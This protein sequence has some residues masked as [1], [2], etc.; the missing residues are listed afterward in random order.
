MKYC[1]IVLLL[2]FFATSFHLTQSATLQ[3]SQFGGKPNGDIA[4]A[5]TSAWAQAC[6]STSA[7]KIVIPAGTYQM[8]HVFLKGPCKAPIELSVDATIKAPVKPEDVGGDEMLRIDYADAL[9]ISGKG[10]FD[11]QGSYAWKQNDCSKK[12]SCKLLGMNF[13]FNFVTNSIVRGITSKDSKHF[14]V[15][16]LGCKNFTFDGFKVTAPENSAN[17][18]G[19]HIGRST[20][21]NVLNT[22]IGTGDDCVSL[23]DGS[24]QVLVQ[25]VKCGP[26]HGISIGSLGKYKEEEPVDGITIKSC[27]IKGTQNGVRIKTWPSQPGTITVTNMR[28]EDITMDNVS[29]PVI[30]DQEYCP[31]NQCTKQYP[32]KIK[33]SKVIIKNIKGTSATKEGIILACSSGVPCEGVEISNVDLKFN[34]A[35][36]IAVCSNVKP[37]ITGKV[38]PCTAPSNKKQ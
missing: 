9:T 33:I 18:D 24:K 6:A 36:A 34:G 13:A 20:G 29:N 37:K 35:P 3:I 5:L 10:V 26:G 17:T 8:T 25:N 22:D 1:T 23:G 16:V 11:G 2:S 28:F 14:H 31:W 30:I 32:S 4:K 7:S 12:F 27:S 21:V 38:P 19:I 15:N